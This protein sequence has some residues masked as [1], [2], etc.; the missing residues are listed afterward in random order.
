MWSHFYLH[1]QVLKC[2][3]DIV[4]AVLTWNLISSNLAMT[5]FLPSHPSLCNSFPAKHIIPQMA[6]LYLPTMA[7]VIFS[8]YLFI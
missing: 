6:H 4:Y 8:I 1:L 7:A 3:C 2:L 5:L